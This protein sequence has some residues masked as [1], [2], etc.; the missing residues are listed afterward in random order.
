MKKYLIHLILILFSYASYAG[1]D[2]DVNDA[3]KAI[4]KKG[5][6]KE[7]ASKYQVPRNLK[8]I[9][10]ARISEI[11]MN[12]MQGG[13]LDENTLM[14]ILSLLD[15]CL[16][17][18]DKKLVKYSLHTLSQIYT[19][20]KYY[21]NNYNNYNLMIGN[22]IYRK[23]IIIGLFQSDDKSIMGKSFNVLAY[24][25]SQKKYV[26]PLLFDRATTPINKD[27]F[28]KLNY[29]RVLGWALNNEN[30]AIKDF[31]I[32]KVM[33]AKSESDYNSITIEAVKSLSKLSNPPEN[34][35]QPIFEMLEGRYFGNPILL[36]AIRNY[37]SL[38]KPYIERLRA[39]KKH[40]DE[41]I[42][43][44]RDKK[45]KG[46]S[47]FKKNQFHNVLRELEKM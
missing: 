24:Y 32:R 21:K 30:V 16:V 47:T 14:K 19:Y 15:Q 44:S 20:N 27:G 22:D 13:V 3:K 46:S 26:A 36:E 43:Y 18:D 12:M 9:D 28:E 11:V 25:F 38:M 23:N 45:G 34:I 40:V 17:S 29:F 6:D 10:V 35:I 2:D 33:S 41:R 4:L 8:N 31:F 39:L 7:I 1:I 37:G 42:L 5:I